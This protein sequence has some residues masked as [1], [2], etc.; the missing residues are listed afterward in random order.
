MRPH[1][2]TPLRAAVPLASKLLL[3]AVL[4]SC[5]FGPSRPAERDPRISFRFDDTAA[6][7]VDGP[8]VAAIDLLGVQIVVDLARRD[9]RL[10]VTAENPT[11]SPITLR[12]GPHVEVA[13]ELSLGE[14]RRHRLDGTP[15]EGGSAYQPF[16]P[17][18]DLAIA[19]A[20]RLL[21]FVDSPSGREPR[22]GDYLV[23]AFEVERAG[24]RP[25]RRLLPI[26]ATAS[27]SRR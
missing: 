1:S 9:A 10:V 25:E 6:W 2:T 22:A 20:T 26:V 18:Q 12:F 7:R 16:L 19:P 23:L 4:A 17:M 5:S 8:D 14:L 3:C 13:R 15:I 27:R 11:G 24:R 21:A